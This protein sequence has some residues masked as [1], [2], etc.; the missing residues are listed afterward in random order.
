[1]S[2]PRTVSIKEGHTWPLLRVAPR[3]ID[4]WREHPKHGVM[5]VPFTVPSASGSR[6]ED[7]LH[8]FF[9]RQ[10]RRAVHRQTAKGVLK[11]IRHGRKKGLTLRY[12]L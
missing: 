10:V 2:L 12:A 6:R 4:V 8:K 3:T 1:M 11:G 7:G 5:L 9:S